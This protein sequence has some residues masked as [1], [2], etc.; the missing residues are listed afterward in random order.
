M[1]VR[2]PS[3]EPAVNVAELLARVD[4]DRELLRELV[5]I[6]K[7]DF[8]GQMS[9]LRQAVA[10]SNLKAV[11][12]FGHSLKGVFFTLAASRAAASAAQL[13]QL[14]RSRD[15]Q[16]LRAELALLE[17]EVALLMPELEPYLTKIE[18]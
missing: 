8:P 14:G 10:Q 18:S 2:H 13:E 3:S 12:T 1:Q 16:G 5:L 9:A 15:R 7:G 4:N 6:F 17:R 11:E